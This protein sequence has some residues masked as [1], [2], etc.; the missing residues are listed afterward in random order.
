M[1]L[2]ELQRQE[3]GLK[4]EEEALNHEKNVH[5]TALKQVTDED[6]SRFSNRPK[7][8]FTVYMQHLQLVSDTRLL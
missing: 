8:G 2:E 7:V 1:H 6:R 4:Q 5:K 3:R